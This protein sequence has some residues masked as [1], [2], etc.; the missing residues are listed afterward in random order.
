[1]LLSI[2]ATIIGVFLLELILR[3]P[4]VERRV[5]APSLYL[6]GADLPVHRVSSDPF[7]HYEM[8]PQVR[9]TARTP[10][11]APYTVNTD[12]FG[13]RCPT[14]AMVKSADTFR[15]LCVG[16]S[17]MYGAGV[18]DDQTIAAALE[19]RLN[20][21]ATAGGRGRFEVWNFGTSGYTLGQAAHL[22]L[23][24][25][26]ALDPDLILVQLHNIGRRPFLATSD[27]SLAD[28]PPGLEDLNADFFM[29]QFPVPSVVPVD[30]H[31]QAL[32]LSA[33]YRSLVALRA[34]WIGIGDN[35][36]CDRCDQI[37]ASAARSLSTVSEGRGVPVVYVAIPADRN[38]P[39]HPFLE[40]GAD[41]FISLY[42]PDRESQF[43]E[44]HPPPSIL[45]EYAAI[46]TDELGK[47]GL[48]IAH[49][50]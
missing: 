13:A 19:R 20:H 32:S 31:L 49:P 41:R 17:T 5:I 9:Y 7:L 34:R 44:V 42:K 27:S 36:Q 40:L 11:G 35:S 33:V 43:Y 14:H 1:M 23:M 30:W 2:A 26:S 45:D 50:R 22:A 39:P 24:K 16:G 29:E 25:L 37:S 6:Q 46:L 48:L 15:I 3:V 21:D 28:H 47:R 38:A 10:D 18:N 4:G 8:A 12:S